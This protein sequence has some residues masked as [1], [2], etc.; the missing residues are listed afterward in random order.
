MIDMPIN[1]TPYTP[2]AGRGVIRLDAA[3][4]IVIRRDTGLDQSLTLPAPYAVNAANVA[5]ASTVDLS[6]VNGDFVNVTGTA[7]INSFGTATAGQPKILVFTGTGTITHNATSL[8]LPGG[9]NISR[10]V[11]D[12]AGFRSLGSGN[13]KCVYYTRADGTA[14]VGGALGPILNAIQGLTPAADKGFY[15]TGPSSVVLF[16]LPLTARNLLD[17]T[18]VAAQRATLA[19]T[20]GTDVQAFNAKL[21]ALVALAGAADKGFYFTGASTMAIYDLSSFAR[22]LL[23]DTTAVAMRATLGITPGANRLASKFTTT[24]NVTTAETSLW[25]FSVPG[26]SLAVDGQ[27]LRFAVSGKLAGNANTKR[28]RLKFGGNLIY[29]SGAFASTAAADWRLTGEFIRSGSGDGRHTVHATATS[30]GI[31]LAVKHGEELALYLHSSSQ[32]FE[33]TAQGTATNDATM[34]MGFLELF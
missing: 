34:E 23:D 5:S 10:L 1:P 33:V 9:V 26:N 12:V 8:I 17:D 16:D 30:S 13:W 21:A 11:G 28:F 7:T 31:P 4:G 24:G 3:G 2:T 20:P 14:V 32:I 29:D 15:F 19:L 6:L 22:T 27:L 18:T 25:S